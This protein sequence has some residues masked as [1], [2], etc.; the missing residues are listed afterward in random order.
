MKEK[1][2][3]SLKIHYRPSQEKFWKKKKQKKKQKKIFQ[4]VRKYC[5]L[6]MD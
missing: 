2:F 4:F 5:E 3:F 1:K 6:V